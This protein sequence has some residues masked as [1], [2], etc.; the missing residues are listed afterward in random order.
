MYGFKE[1]EYLA[2]VELKRILAK[3]GYTPSKFTPGLYTHKVRD[4]AFSLVVDDFGVRYTN[5]KDAE[6]LAQAIA[7]RYPIKCDWD[8]NYYLGITLEFDYG[9]RTV[10]MSM[11]GYVQEALLY[12]QHLSQEVKCYGPSPYTA[13]VYG[14]KTQMANI[15]TTEPLRKQ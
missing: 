9:A 10:K 15:D 4:I 3:E 6:H 8:P 7:K 12:F 13:P 5:K 1:S 11:P 2:N 14:R